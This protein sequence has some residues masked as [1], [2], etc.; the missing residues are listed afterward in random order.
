MATNL[1]KV[2]SNKSGKTQKTSYSSGNK[3]ITES[4]KTKWGTTT[5]TKPVKKTTSRSR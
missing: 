3:Y 1:A 4:K 2:F 5:T